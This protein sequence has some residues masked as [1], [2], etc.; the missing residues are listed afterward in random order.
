MCESWRAALTNR[1]RSRHGVQLLLRVEKA[2]AKSCTSATSRRPARSSI[3]PS[4]S[5]SERGLL[6][7]ALHPTSTLKP[8]RLSFWT[9]SSTGA[10]HDQHTDDAPLLGNRVDSFT[11]T[12]DAHVRQELIQ[13]PRPS[14]GAGSPS[15][16]ITTGGVI[17]FGPER[18]NLHHHG[19]NGSSRPD[20]KLALWSFRQRARPLTVDDQFRWSRT[21]QRASLRRRPAR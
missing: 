19:D 10:R 1:L 13:T 12:A 14:T 15:R 5:A 4:N 6:G 7:I 18:Q 20:A 8:A 3:S 17:R 11:G 2:S 16:A 21:R 9:E